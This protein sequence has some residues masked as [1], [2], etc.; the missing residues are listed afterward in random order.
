MTTETKTFYPRVVS[1]TTGGKY[2]KFND[3]DVIKAYDKEKLILVVNKIDLAKFEELYP[4]LD[5]F[6]ELKN[7]VDIVP[8][9]AKRGDNVGVLIDVIKKYLTSNVKYFDSD[10]YTDKSVRYIVKEIIREKALWYLQDEVPHGVAVEIVEYDEQDNLTVISADI[11]CEKQS[12]KAIII[13]KD[14]GMLKTIGSSARKDIEQVVGTKVMLK[15]F[16][17]VRE[18]WRDNNTYIKDLGYEQNDL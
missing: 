18:G 15:L 1:Q 9:S 11:V 5:N 12:H 4:K 8:L 17:K 7:I 10:V 16:V 2:A 3:L 6:N 14:G 13:G